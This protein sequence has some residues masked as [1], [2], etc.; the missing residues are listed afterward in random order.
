MMENEY[1]WIWL[2]WG[3]FNINFDY[4]LPF[5]KFG[6]MDWLFAGLKG[7]QSD[8]SITGLPL[9]NVCKQ[10][11]YHNPK[12]WKID[13][14]EEGGRK[15]IH[16]GN[17]Y[18]KKFKKI[19]IILRR[20]GGLEEGFKACRMQ[21]YCLYIWLRIWSCCYCYIYKELPLGMKSKVRGKFLS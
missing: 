20:G 14:K 4:F 18:K 7:F 16:E 10:N 12:T 9:I 13:K 6:H 8:S 1:V 3:P 21:C 17:W 19:I 15:K 2:I 5:L 11:R